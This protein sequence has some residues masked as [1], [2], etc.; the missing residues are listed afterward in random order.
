MLT[1]RTLVE[2]AGRNQ[3][4]EQ[5]LMALNV[6]VSSRVEALDARALFVDEDDNEH[7]LNTKEFAEVMRDGELIHPGYG[8]PVPDFESRLIPFF[9]PS[10]KFCNMAGTDH[11]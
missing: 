6:L 8:E 10:K 5:L 9:V 4:D 1:Y 3:V 11:G 7:E 2:V